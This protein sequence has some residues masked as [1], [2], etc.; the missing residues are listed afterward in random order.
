MIRVELH[1]YDPYQYEDNDKFY[2]R[3]REDERVKRT[4]RRKVHQ[5]ANKKF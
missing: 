3:Y 5:A 1:P 2:Q 4:V